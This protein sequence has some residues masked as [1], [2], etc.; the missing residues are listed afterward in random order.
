MSYKLKFCFRLYRLMTFDLIFFIKILRKTKIH[1]FIFANNIK[2][3][4]I[5]LL[6]LLVSCFT[7]SAQPELK[8]KSI[9]G[10]GIATPMQTKPTEQKP[11][12]LFKTPLNLPSISKPNLGFESKKPSVFQDNSKID[13]SKQNIFANPNEGLLDKLNRKGLAVTD[14][15]KEV[16][17]NQDF[18]VFALNSKFVNIKCR[19]FGEVDGDMVRVYINGIVVENSIYLDS[20][21][22]AV[23]VFLVKGFNKIEIE[24]L[25]QGTSGPNTAD[26]QV[27]DDNGKMVSSNQ[28]NLATGFKATIMVT[29]D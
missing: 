28:W 1:T 11:S 13:L 22:K 4:R 7:V 16:R 5:L 8:K 2:I 25:N 17:G 18:G 15:F 29:K 27:F 19:D 20:Y 3:M 10:A 12:D 21:Y 24:A 26:F 14:D 6:T 23:D 9:S